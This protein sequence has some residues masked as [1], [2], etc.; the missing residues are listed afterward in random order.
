MSEKPT[1]A[2]EYTPELTDLTRATCLYVATRL[3][4]LKVSLRTSSR[5]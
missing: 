2:S 5:A 4:D 3:G 1:S